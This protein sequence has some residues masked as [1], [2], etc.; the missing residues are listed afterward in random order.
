MKKLLDVG[1]DLLSSAQMIKPAL[2]GDVRI[3]MYIN[4]QEAFAKD[5][6]PLTTWRGM[7]AV[8]DRGPWNDIEMTFPGFFDGAW[9]CDKFTLIGEAGTMSIQF[10]GTLYSSANEDV[11]GF[12]GSWFI[13]ESTG[14]YAG[15]TGDGKGR[16]IL[17]LGLAGIGMAW[18]SGHVKPAKHH[19][20]Y[21]DVTENPI[22]QQEVKAG[23]G[24]RAKGRS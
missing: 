9:L 4:L 20:T 13:Y 1:A 5:G 2:A 3:F 23:A 11:F 10:D 7:G 22:G 19:P 14:T 24:A 18:L 8:S 6:A 21:R 16:G 12:D 17:H 15:A